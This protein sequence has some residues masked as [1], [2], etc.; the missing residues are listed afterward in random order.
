MRRDYFEVECNGVDEPSN[1]PVISIRYD[2]PE[3]ML[4]D[5]LTTDDG[6]LDASDLDVTYRLTAGGDTGPTGVL[7]ITDRL[8]GDFVLETNVEPD[9]IESLVG[10]ASDADE[11]SYRLRLTDSAGKSTVYDKE[12]LLVYDEDGSLRRADSLIPGGVEL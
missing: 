11:P 3:G 6:T 5:R 2:G 1:R 12:L 4:T 9:A 8:T 10:A 7:S